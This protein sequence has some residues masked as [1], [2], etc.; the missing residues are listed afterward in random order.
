VEVGVGYERTLG[1]DGF[2]FHLDL[3]ASAGFD[4]QDRRWLRSGLTFVGEGPVFDSWR[5]RLRGFVG[6]AVGWDA[7]DQDWNHATVPRERMFFLAGG[8]P[9]QGMSNP[10]TRSRGATLDEEGF[11]PGGGELRGFHPGLPVPRIAA[12]GVEL[13]SPALLS[14]RAARRFAPRLVAFG[15]AGVG[16]RIPMA[17]APDLD[18][19]TLPEDLHDRWRRYGSAGLGLE[20]GRQG[21]PVRLRFDVPFLISDPGL[22]TGATDATAGFRWTVSILGG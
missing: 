17:G 18:P 3:F 21:S 9:L 15:N 12:V 7:R 10:W 13:A 19:E 1:R 5:A 16:G 6:A 8:D 22:A 20:V 2:P 4:T 14:G 11:V